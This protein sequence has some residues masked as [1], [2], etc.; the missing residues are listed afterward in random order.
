[1]SRW[2]SAMFSDLAPPR[3]PREVN[4]G[5]FALCCLL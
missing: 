5:A 3:R 4:L 1:M 2:R